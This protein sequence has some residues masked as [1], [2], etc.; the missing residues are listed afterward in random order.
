[1]R[2]TGTSHPRASMYEA[3]NN[4]HARHE[5]QAPDGQDA[6]RE[7]ETDVAHC[8]GRGAN[9]RHLMSRMLGTNSRHRMGRM[10]GTN[11]RR[12]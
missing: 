6:R 7:H 5:Q 11:T 2:D 3:N 9:S 12:A 1:M 10:H 4:H 8:M